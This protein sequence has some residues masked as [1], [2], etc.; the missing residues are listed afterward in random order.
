MFDVP[1]RLAL[2]WALVGKGYPLSK[3]L[4]EKKELCL[5]DYLSVS[6]NSLWDPSPPGRLHGISLTDFGN[7]GKVLTT[8][9]L[10]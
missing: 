4:G 1:V 9:N 6:G 8:A 7:P 2:A 3:V 10:C 5:S